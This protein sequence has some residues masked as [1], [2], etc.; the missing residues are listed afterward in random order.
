MAHRV[1]ETL[2]VE[3]DYILIAFIDYPLRSPQ[4]VV[5]ALPWSEAETPMGEL[6]LIDGGQ[7]LIDGLLHQPVYNRRDTQ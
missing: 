1:E 5:T 7:Y 2:K 4:R 6:L 3:V